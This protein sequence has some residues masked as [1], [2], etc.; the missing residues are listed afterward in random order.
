MTACV[1]EVAGTVHVECINSRPS[2]SGKWLA[3]TIGPVWIETPEQV[4]EIFER[5][6][7]DGRLKFYI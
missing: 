4:L 3:V 2:K 7:A 6:K 5:M 1:Q